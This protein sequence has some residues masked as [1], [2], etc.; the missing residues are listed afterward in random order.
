V[1]APTNA[2]VLT[3]ARPTS[4][5]IAA[6]SGGFTPVPV[7]GGGTAPVAPQDPSN[8]TATQTGDGTVR[9]AWEPVAGAGSYLLGGPGLNVGI[10]VNG[11]SHTVSGIPPGS[12]TWTVATMYASGGVLTTADRWARATTSVVNRSGRY[13][14]AVNG[15]RVNRVTF[16]DRTFGNG[17]EVYASAAVTVLDRR[18]NAVLS[19]RTVIGSDTYGDVS[20]NP[21]RVRAGSF[22][23]TGGLW[24]GDVVPGGTEPRSA[25]GVPSAR[26]FP[27][28]LWE[29]ALQDGVE[30]VVV[31]PVLWEVDGQLQYFDLWA[32]PNHS[33]RRQPARA[34]AQAAAIR[35]RAARGDLTPY[36]GPLVF[37]CSSSSDVI[38]DCSP[39]ND[40]PIGINREPCLADTFVSNLLAWCEQTMVFT[41][42]AIEGALS[43]TSQIGGAAAGVI[44][45]PLIEPSGVDAI[46]GG[47]EG[48]YELYLR[49][50][51][52]P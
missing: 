35:D 21:E 38:P 13:R 27:W 1:S 4:P 48:S 37:I 26:R 47:L 22:S 45:L 40:R 16:D 50:E 19:G 3:P 31:N 32:D 18:N 23:P 39:G 52:L 49:V 29:G 12:H 28:I 46:K 51:R 11:T 25:T 44:T 8:F 41:R 9:L 43:S 34:D 17:D 10:T 36:R 33:T 2:G 7:T 15:F 5:P 14:I 6:P 20:R 30:A 42:E 24:T